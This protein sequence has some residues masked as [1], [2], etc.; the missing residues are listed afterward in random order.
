MGVRIP[1]L[2]L[3]LS[4]NVP[5]FLNTGTYK[6]KSIIL[7]YLYNLKYPIKQFYGIF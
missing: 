2:V 6:H 5:V 4:C 3:W 7:K 1:A